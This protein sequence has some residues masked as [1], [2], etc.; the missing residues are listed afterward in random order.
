M[1]V[2]NVENAKVTAYNAKVRTV[3]SR[4]FPAIARLSCFMDES[5]S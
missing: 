1:K 5:Q 3:A 4:G 2:L